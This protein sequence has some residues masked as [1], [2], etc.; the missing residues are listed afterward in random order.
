M[1]EGLL[2][3]VSRLRWTL[4]ALGALLLLNALITPGFFGVGVREGRLYGVPIDILSHSAR[5]GI[6]ALAMTLVIATGGID[7]SVGAVVAVSGALGAWLV[8]DAGAPW[9]AAMLAALAAGLA[10]G[11]WNGALVTLLGLQPIVA[12]LVLMVAGRGIAQLI[13]GG[14]IMTFRSPAFEFLA[15]GAPLAIPMPI[16]LFAFAATAIG[17]GVRRTSLGLFVECVGENSEAARLCGV[18]SSVVRLGVYSLCG[19]CAAL[20]GLIECAYID[21]ADANNAGLGFELDAILAVV[22]GGTALSGGRFL[23]SGT[24]LGA[25]LIQTITKTMYMLDVPAEIA[26]AP[27]ALIVLAVC[28]AQSPSLRARLSRWRARP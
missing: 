26:P 22:I 11:A 25:I 8:T 20:A 3:T 21:A 19:L 27:K 28:V 7:L 23:L 13:T 16:W 1:H 5:V 10:L 6:I 17:L 4:L 2:G 24:V 18:P 9:P 14:T 12:T 15:D